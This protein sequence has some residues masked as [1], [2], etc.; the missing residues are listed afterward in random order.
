MSVSSDSYHSFVGGASEICSAALYETHN[1]F[2]CAV[3]TLSAD[4]WGPVFFVPVI[5]PAFVFPLL[6]FF[7][8]VTTTVLSYFLQI[9]VISFCIHIR[10]QLQHLSP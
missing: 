5:E 2:L 4:S 8:P 9:D 1:K 7:P 6:S 10:R 3:G